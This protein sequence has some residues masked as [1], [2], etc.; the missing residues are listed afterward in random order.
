MKININLLPP[1]FK[2]E[3]IKKAKFV[4]IQVIGIITIMF[5]VFLASMTVTL[6][7]LQNQNIKHI[8]GRISDSEKKITDQKS[9]QV[10][11]MLLK[12]RLTAINKYFGT[13]SKQSE[14]YQL[15]MELLP[16]SV[17]VNSFSVKKEGDILLLAVTK[18]T[19]SLDEMA[20]TLIY[21]NTYQ[22]KISSLS[23]DNLSRGRDGIYRFSLRIKP[24]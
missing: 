2:I 3:Q 24:K 23:L 13:V 14:M 12:N 6:G 4:K 10:S 18:D 9:T 16:A 15:V 21:K 1:E 22:D 8:K 19:A 11:L 5:V 20:N 7:I 17:S